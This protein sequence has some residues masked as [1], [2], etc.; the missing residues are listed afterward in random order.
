[1]GDSCIIDAEMV[2]T[3]S[4]MGCIQTLIDSILNLSIRSLLTHVQTGLP[5]L[6]LGKPSD[7]RA[8]EFVAVLGSLFSLQ[9][10]VT[11]GIVST[12]Q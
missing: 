3:V 2:E 5:V 4:Y 12:T 9:N 7:L 1:M 10:T 8:G 11:A 6:L